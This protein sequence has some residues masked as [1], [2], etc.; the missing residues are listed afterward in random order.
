[1]IRMAGAVL[2]AVGTSW[3][4]IRAAGTL[5]QELNS[6]R[7][8]S[9][10]LALLERELEWDSPPLPVLMRR[11]VPQCRNPMNVVF[12]GVLRAL[13]RLE[14]ET[15]TDNWAMLIEQQAE[16]DAGTKRVLLPLGSVLGR[17]SCEEQRRAVAMVRERLDRL[18]QELMGERQRK[19]RL[20]R[21]LGVSGGS[22]LA[23]LLL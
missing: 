6:L 17:C 4:G 20:Y 13:D 12:Q 22:F 7:A 1:M 3:L 15:L 23:L 8:A 10:A 21:V 9:E 11:I 2:V 5:D 19:G 16:F 14:E 18:E